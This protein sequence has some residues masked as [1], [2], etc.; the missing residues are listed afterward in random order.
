MAQKPKL[1]MVYA[2]VRRLHTQ[3]GTI[4]TDFE[5][6]A[7][8]TG[9]A[10]LEAAAQQCERMAKYLKLLAADGESESDVPVSREV[11]VTEASA[12]GMQPRVR[13]PT[14]LMGVGEALN[15]DGFP[16]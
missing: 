10:S 14:Q 15:E 3:I 1:I 2:T 7:C 5:E 6:L 4:L 12:D 11:D 16:R 9:P 8:S 13:E